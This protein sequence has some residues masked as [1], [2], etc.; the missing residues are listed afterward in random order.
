M[1]AL[2]GS[3]I[4]DPGFTIDLAGLNFVELSDDESSAKI[5]S[6][7]HWGDAYAPLFEKNLTVMGGRD[8][9]VGVG[10]FLIGG[11]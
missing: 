1:E 11:E 8:P 4:E 9:G 6:G 3:N 7:L 5:G 2:G 10:G